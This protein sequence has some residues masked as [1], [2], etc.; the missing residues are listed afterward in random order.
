MILS[1]A[2]LMPT[3]QNCGKE[4][5]CTLIDLGDQPL[6]NAY[7]TSAEQI[8]Q[9][10]KFPLHARVCNNCWLVQVDDVVPVDEIFNSEYAYFSSYSAGWLRHCQDY[11][12][13]MAQEFSLNSESLVIELASNDGYMLQYFVK[14]GIPVLGIEPSNNTA[15]SALARGVATRVEFF[16]KENARSL[17]DEG[18][19]ADL[20][21]AK[22]VLAHVPDINDFVAGLPQVLKAEGVFTVEFPHLLNLLRYHQFD[23]IY[24]EH[25]TYLS[26]I[27]IQRLFASHG[28]RVFDVREQ[29]THGGSLR[30]FACHSSA[31][32][33]TTPAV[34]RILDEERAY[35][36]ETMSGY[37]GFEGKAKSIRDE[38]T[39]FLANCKRDGKTVAAYGAAA[40]GNTFLNYCGVGAEDLAYV[41]DRN[42]AKQEKLLPG[43]HVPV[44]A[45]EYADAN[46]PDFMVILPWN[47]REEVISQ[48]QNLA[49]AGT[50]FVTA[51]PVLTVF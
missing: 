7:L 32:H 14:M 28:L 11:A 48:N 9:E 24:H 18:L 34:A 41:V 33:A 39:S 22:N 2:A 43:S 44:V 21:A 36:M 49:A 30:V 35:G 3:C 5:S 46:R 40:K 15:A 8:A 6:A 1:D 25:F 20:V 23:T 51:I 19:L 42:P 12:E 45:P 17:R 50:R 10:R 4:L 38:F 26:M 27:V 16:N 47:I 37:T 29:P 13:S 31:T